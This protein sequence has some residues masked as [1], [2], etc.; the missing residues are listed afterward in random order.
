MS[1]VGHLQPAV[2]VL[3]DNFVRF[4]A[5]DARDVTGRGD[6]GRQEQFPAE[7]RS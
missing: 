6:Y 3:D 7:Q 1:A 2:R 5:D 4:S